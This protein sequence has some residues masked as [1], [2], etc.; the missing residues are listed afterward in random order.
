[1][2]LQ[3]AQRFGPG[4][5]AE[6]CTDPSDEMENLLFALTGDVGPPE[7]SEGRLGLPVHSLPAL[8][9]FQCSGT[10]LI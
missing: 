3:G 8:N 2:L 1:M 7:R 5:P 9:G 4:G 6:G 10:I